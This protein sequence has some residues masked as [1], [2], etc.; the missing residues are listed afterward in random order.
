MP[1]IELNE[2]P[3]LCL[4]RS[5]VEKI[6]AVTSEIGKDKIKDSLLPNKKKLFKMSDCTREEASGLLY[7]F[8]FISPLG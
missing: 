8:N 7:S 5:M 4:A 1:I 3:Q 6:V 2:A